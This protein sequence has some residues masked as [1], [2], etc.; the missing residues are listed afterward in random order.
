MVRMRG[1]NDFKGKGS[2]AWSSTAIVLRGG[3]GGSSSLRRDGAS[4]RS[5]V[6]A[7]DSHRGRGT[8]HHGRNDGRSSTTKRHV[9]VDVR[10][11][12]R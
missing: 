6:D 9:S 7:R 11:P 3:S 1:E 8:G 10:I 2:R 12:A 5:I 4:R